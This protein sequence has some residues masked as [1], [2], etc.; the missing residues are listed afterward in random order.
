[1]QTEPPK[2]EPP[3]LKR[4]WFQFSLRTLLIFTLVVAIAC[5]W[6]GSKIEKKRKEREAVEAIL[7]AGGIVVYDYQKPSMIS[8]RTFKPVEEPYGPEFLRNFLGENFFSEVYAVQHSNTTLPDEELEFLERFPHMEDLNLSGCQ[9]SVAGAARLGRL[10]AIR[11]LCLGG[12]SPINF[13]QIKELKLL[14][15]LSLSGANVSD[16]DLVGIKQLSQLKTLFLSQTNVTD[17]CLEELKGLTNLQT[18][19]LNNTS[20]TADGL[21]RFHAALPK[22]TIGH[23][24]GRAVSKELS[25]AR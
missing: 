12:A 9:M 1:M 3:K 18:L 19:L 10:A 11:S 13:D 23:S 15:T 16:A 2:T 4:R 7:K 20:V 25:L 24:L 17:N 22:C 21:K 8:G 14:E 6:L 5:A